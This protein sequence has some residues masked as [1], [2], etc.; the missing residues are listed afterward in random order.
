MYNYSKNINLFCLHF[1]QI[2]V[3][4]IREGIGLCYLMFDGK[5]LLLLTCN[6]VR[7]LD[8]IFMLP[9]CVLQSQPK[10]VLLANYKK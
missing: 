9:W 1:L 6:F 2:D 7:T 3:F 5:L 4:L 10:V 8:V